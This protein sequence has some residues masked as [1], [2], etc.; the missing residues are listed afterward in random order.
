FLLK[1]VFDYEH[2]EIAGI[3]GTTTENSRQLLHRAKAKLA[4]GRPEAPIAVPQSRAVAERFARAFADGGAEE[5]T[6][7]LSSDVGLWSDGGGKATASL[8][9]LLGRDRVLNLLV[10]L[11][12]VAQTT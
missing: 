11:H 5:L 6:A 10:G 4:K 9:P 8:R 3:L 1:D 2:A 12:R 7:I